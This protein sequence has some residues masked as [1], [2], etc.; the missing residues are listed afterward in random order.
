[1]PVFPHPLNKFTTF[2]ERRIT[3]LPFK[4]LDACIP[5]TFSN[6]Q[7]FVYGSNPFFSYLFLCLLDNAFPSGGFDVTFQFEAGGSDL[8]AYAS[9]GES[10]MVTEIGHFLLQVFPFS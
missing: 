3:Y 2:F 6:V 1:M 4:F 10:L 5:S 7:Y 8:L 9:K